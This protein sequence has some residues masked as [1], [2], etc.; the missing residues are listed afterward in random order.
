MGLTFDVN[1]SLPNSRASRK[2]VVRLVNGFYEED[3]ESESENTPS[4][5][6]KGHVAETLEKSANELVESR[7]RLPK[8][9]CKQVMTYIDKYGLDYKAMARDPTNYYQETWRQ[10]RA[11]CRK[12]LS[13]PEQCT[14][15]LAASGYL[16][17]EI[18]END[19]RWKEAETDDD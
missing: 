1:K 2:K 9:V 10:I 11:K 14:E 5:K 8:G 12:F 7:F 17:E 4:T 3:I 13:I 19:P 6:L 16:D 15:F 18:A